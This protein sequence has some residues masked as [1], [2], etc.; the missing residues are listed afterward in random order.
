METILREWIGSRGEPV[1]V[2]VTR[3]HVCYWRGT[4]S[5]PF[6]RVA[7]QDWLIGREGRMAAFY[8]GE[9]AAEEVCQFVQALVEQTVQE[10]DVY[11]DE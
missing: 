8:V 3:Q 1:G 6:K 11:A 2:F 7:L 4:P 5:H 9:A 10:W